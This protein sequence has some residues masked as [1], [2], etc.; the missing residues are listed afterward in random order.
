[1]EVRELTEEN[2]VIQEDSTVDLKSMSPDELHAYL[3]PKEARKERPAVTRVG[4]VEQVLDNG[5]QRLLV[6]KYRNMYV[7]M[8]GSELSD[9]NQKAL[10]LELINSRIS[11]K[12]IGTEDDKIIVSER[13]INDF[14]K[15]ALESNKI[16]KGK[17]VALR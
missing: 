9:K 12:P 10:R 11:F 5:D 4:I 2:A 16:L 7:Y 13:A 6:I 17:F 8:F 1:M 14:Y 3:I 15:H